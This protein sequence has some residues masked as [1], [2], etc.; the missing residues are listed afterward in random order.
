MKRIQAVAAAIVALAA[1]RAGGQARPPALAHQVT[2][3]YNMDGV[4]SPDGSSLLF[5]RIVEG[6]EQLFVLPIGGGGPERQIPRADADHEDPAWSPDG[7]R[8]AFIRIAG[9]EKRVMIASA[10]GSGAEPV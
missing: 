10:D 8:I 6:R 7:A 2:Y 1:D 9:G 4:P 5:I 3:S